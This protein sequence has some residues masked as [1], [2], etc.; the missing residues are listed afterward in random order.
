MQFVRVDTRV[1]DQDVVSDMELQNSA[2]N[3]TASE[4]LQGNVD[5][6]QESA[7]HRRFRFTDSRGLNEVAGQGRKAGDR[8]FIDVR[9]VIAGAEVHLRREILAHDVDGELAIGADVVERV[10]GLAKGIAHGGKADYRRIGADGG[11]ETERGEVA[12]AFV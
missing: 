1:P 2:E 9:R 7:F 4:R 10:F 11:E 3:Q 8:E 12:D 5:D 6:L